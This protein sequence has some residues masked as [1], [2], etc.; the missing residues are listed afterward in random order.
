MA[1]T[2]EANIIKGSKTNMN[3]VKTYL[4][5]FLVASEVSLPKFQ[6]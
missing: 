5:Y 6:E 3:L 1:L 4:Q 2:V